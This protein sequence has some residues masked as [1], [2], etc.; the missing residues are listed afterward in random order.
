VMADGR[1]E[2]AMPVTRWLWLPAEDGS[3]TV[4]N[5]VDI[6]ETAR[7]SAGS[8]P[9]PGS[10]LPGA[11]QPANADRARVRPGYAEAGL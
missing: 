8:S 3:I 9:V 11:G 6:P 2:A 1:G 10:R 7:S 5:P 4:A